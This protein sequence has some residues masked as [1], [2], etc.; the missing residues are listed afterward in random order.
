TR[1]GV[2]PPARAPREPPLWRV[3][4]PR[5][6]GAVRGGRARGVHNRR[7]RSF[8]GERVDRPTSLPGLLRT[9]QTPIQLDVPGEDLHVISCLTIG[10]PF[11]EQLL[12]PVLGEGLPRV[13]PVRAGVV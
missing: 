8:F 1:P 6:P 5:G 7:S 10:D 12:V 4:R 3:H 2:S 13:D 11:G 9:I